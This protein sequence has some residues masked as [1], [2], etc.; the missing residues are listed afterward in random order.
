MTRTVVDGMNVIG[1]RADGW[2]RDRDGAARRLL[3]QLQHAVSR[4]E[5][6]LTLV[7][8]GRPPAD[9]AEGD[10][11]GVDVQYARRAG[12]DAADD[13]IVEI[14]AADADPTGLRVVTSDR[15]LAARV[16]ALG[17]TTEGAG[18]FL[19]RLDRLGA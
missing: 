11:C 16:I 2:W 17:A 10:H 3:R 1:A 9:L 15:E 7:L 14:V 8:D 5:D 19:R 12:R 4:T 13:R 6:A 18:S